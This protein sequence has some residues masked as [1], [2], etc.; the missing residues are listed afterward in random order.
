[1][2][3]VLNSITA[4]MQDEA[5]AIEGYTN[6]LWIA[7]DELEPKDFM[8]L[9]ETVAEIISDELNHVTR[10]QALYSMLSDI[11]TGAE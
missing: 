2:Y 1:M 9:Y 7:Q 5:K 3:P 8:N 6:L 10:L 4:N 11:E